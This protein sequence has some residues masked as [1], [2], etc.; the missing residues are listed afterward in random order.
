MTE[1][2]VTPSSTKMYG[3]LLRD[4]TYTYDDTTLRV[5]RNN[6]LEH[7]LRP[8]PVINFTGDTAPGSPNIDN[9]D[10][11]DGIYEG[12]DIDALVVGVFNGPTAVV[13]IDPGPPAIITV[14]QNADVGAGVDQDFEASWKVHLARIYAFS[15]EGTVYGLPRP[16]IF[17]VHGPGRPIDFT[18]GITSSMQSAGVAAREWEFSSGSDLVYWEYEKGDFSLR[19]DTEAGPL[20]QILLAAAIRGADMA[21]RS[22]ANLG[23]RSGANLSGANVSGANVSGANLSGANLS[24]ANLRNR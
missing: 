2:L 6:F 9:A 24:G 1:T 14:S 16:S 12:M 8:S 20:E 13:N 22:G 17:V 5:A 7:Q 4:L 3:R 10:P 11:I 18:G 23:V 21:D 15:F 19:L